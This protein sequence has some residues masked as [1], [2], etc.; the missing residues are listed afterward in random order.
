M[1]KQLRMRLSKAMALLLCELTFCLSVVSI[2]LFS[3]SSSSA[4]QTSSWAR[5]DLWLFD[6]CL[7]EDPRPSCV[8]SRFNEEELFVIPSPRS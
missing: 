3:P 2:E 5:S 4:W 1:T 6:F 8:A 7:F